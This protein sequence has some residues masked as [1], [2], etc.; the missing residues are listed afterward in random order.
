MNSSSRVHLAGVLSTE[1]AAHIGHD[2][3]DPIR[4]HVERAGQLAVYSVRPL[5]PRPYRQTIVVPLG[6]GRAWFHRGMLDIGDGIRFAKD[7]RRLRERLVH[8]AP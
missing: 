1:P 4:R 5:G 6:H 8:R 7:L 3:T 2:D